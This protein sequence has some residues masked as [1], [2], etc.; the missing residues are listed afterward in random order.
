V[1]RLHSVG[2]LVGMPNLDAFAVVQAAVNLIRS[3]PHAPA[4]DVLDQVMR[5]RAGQVLDFDSV[6]LTA[7]C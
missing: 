3:R 7:T 6:D 4:L 2:R 5:G 1:A